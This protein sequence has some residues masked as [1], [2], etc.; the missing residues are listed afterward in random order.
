MA[1]PRTTPASVDDYIAAFP[2]DVQAVLR[3][4]RQAVREA[5][6]QATEVISYQM[7]ALRQHG[8]LVF[9]AAFKKHVGFYPPITGD[10]R[11]EQAAAKYAGEKGNLRFPLD[12]PMPLKLIKGL[13]ALRVAQD[14]AHAAEK[15]K[16][17]AR[18]RTAAAPGNAA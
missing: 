13:T 3:Q 6:P 1:T 12:E 5:A 8:I 15:K 10:A 14:A 16:K 11:L 17:A 9:F 7:P 18:K 2:A 4:V